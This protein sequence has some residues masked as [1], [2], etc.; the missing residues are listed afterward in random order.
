MLEGII[1]I[2]DKRKHPFKLAHVEPGL[3]VVG[4]LALCQHLESDAGLRELD[5]ATMHEN[6]LHREIVVLADNAFP[7][8]LM[9]NAG[10]HTE[11]FFFHKNNRLM[12]NG[13]GLM[14]GDIIDYFFSI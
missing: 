11:I 8:L 7:I 13:Y 3:S 10:S 12:I 1:L 4:Q 9:A 14:I 6:H 2:K 5:F